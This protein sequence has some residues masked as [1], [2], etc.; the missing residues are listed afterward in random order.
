MSAFWA[1]LT[2]AEMQCWLERTEI[3]I[4]PAKYEPFG[5]AVPEAAGALL[6]KQNL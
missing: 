3:Y 6:Q 4:N 5:L 1:K 2:P